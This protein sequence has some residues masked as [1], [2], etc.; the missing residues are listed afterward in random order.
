[1][2][3]P[4]QWMSAMPTIGIRRVAC[5][6]IAG[7]CARAA[8]GDATAAPPSSVMNARRLI[9]SP[10][11]PQMRTFLTGLL[12]AVVP[13]IGCELPVASD[14]LPHHEIFAGDFLRPRTLGL[15]AEGPDL[16]R[17]GGPEGLD[18]E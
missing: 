6:G 3:Q 16:S 8:I 15:E 17:R 5:A 14:L 10:H 4:W 7:C 12:L 18:V 11:W 13:D 2:T 9:R 1:M